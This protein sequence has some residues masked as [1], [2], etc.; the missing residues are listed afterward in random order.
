MSKSGELK[1]LLKLGIDPLSELSNLQKGKTP[2]SGK[3]IVITGT[4]K[5]PRS[6][7]VKFLKSYGVNV[8]SSV[9]KNTDYL[10]VGKAAGSKTKKAQE[11]GVKTLSWMD[12]NKLI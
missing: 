2:L 11:L 5:I 8:T 10:L 12:L 6:Q 4:F 3:K 7:V 9:S 1:I